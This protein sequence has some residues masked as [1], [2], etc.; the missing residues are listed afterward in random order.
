MT[1]TTTLK[2]WQAELKEV[3]GR[4]RTRTLTETEIVEAAAELSDGEYEI[5]RGG[6]VA[7]SYGYAAYQTVALVWRDLGRTYAAVRLAGASRGS[8]GFGDVAIRNGKSKTSTFLPKLTKRPEE[9]PQ[10]FPWAITEQL[11]VAC[12]WL[13]TQGLPT[14]RP[15][16]AGREISPD[17]LWKTS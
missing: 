3:N 6:T 9:L 1:T 16:I 13:E 17:D 4:R 7:N 2:V 12:D 11:L 5:V 15:A 8:T 14:V 10:G